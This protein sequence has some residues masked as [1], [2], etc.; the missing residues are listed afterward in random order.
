MTRGQG[1]FRDWVTS[2]LDSRSN[3]H[4]QNS[5]FGTTV[6]NYTSQIPSVL[7]DVT[8]IIV[9][10]SFNNYYSNPG[11]PQPFRCSNF[12]ISV[13]IFNENPCTIHL[14]ILRFFNILV[15]GLLSKPS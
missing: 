11:F 13:F 15:N 10:Q 5:C 3:R 7:E 2:F 14:L 6:L 4:G 1:G 8:K 9:L 12:F